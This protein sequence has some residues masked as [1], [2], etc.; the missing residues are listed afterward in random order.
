VLLF[1]TEY[2]VLQNAGLMYERA[3]QSEKA[4]RLHATRWRS[5]RTGPAALVNLGR[6]LEA[7]GAATRQYLVSKCGSLTIQRRTA[8]QQGGTRERDP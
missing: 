2:P 6:I 7:C 5:S 3:S 4:V 8:R 1:G